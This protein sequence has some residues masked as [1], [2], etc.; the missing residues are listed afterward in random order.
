MKLAGKVAIVTGAAQGI[1]KAIAKRFASEGASVVVADVK[2]EKAGRIADE[3]KAQG[4]TAVGAQVD[5]ADKSEVQDMVRT[6]IEKFEAIHILVNNAGIMRRA[7]LLEL[8]EE[9]WDTTINVDLKGVFNCTQAVLPHMIKQRYGK[10]INISS[11]AGAGH[12][13]PDL[14]S[15]AAAKAGVI[16]LTKVTAREAGQYGINVNSIS[17]G[18][19]ATSLGYVD[20]TKEETE[21]SVEQRKT[22]T[23]LGRPGMPEDV[24]NLALFL[25]SEESSFITGQIITIDGGRIDGI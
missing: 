17:P 9:A 23:L 3:I 5:V 19:I 2:F 14:A 11:I 20:R 25:A 24:A 15:Y 4:G 16:Q 6:A 18:L 7:P 13:G 10:I 1:G 12:A 8:T 22:I 21:E